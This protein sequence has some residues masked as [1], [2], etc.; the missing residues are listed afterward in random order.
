MTIHRVEE[1]FS[2]L[3]KTAIIKLQPL[4]PDRY[5]G[6]RTEQAED[7]QPSVVSMVVIEKEGEQLT[8]L[9]L[10]IYF[11]TKLLWCLPFINEKSLICCE[12]EEAAN[13]CKRRLLEQTISHI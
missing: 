3:L 1:V 13:L 5:E 11:F 8:V 9:Y 7:V 12:S 4:I 2:F 10:Y 6:S